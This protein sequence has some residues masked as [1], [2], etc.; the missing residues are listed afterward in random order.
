[1][2][3]GCG[4]IDTPEHDQ[5]GMRV[6]GVGDARHLAV[7]RLVGRAGRRRADRPRQPRRAERAKERASLVSCVSRPFD[8]P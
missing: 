6:I 3:S 1:M 4:G 2:D 8:P 7:E 5:P